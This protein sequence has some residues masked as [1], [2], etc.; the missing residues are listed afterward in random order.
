MA[1]D[2]DPG[3]SE[4][5][6]S[7]KMPPI[8]TTS[9]AV[10]DASRTGLFDDDSLN[11]LMEAQRAP[12]LIVIRG[13]VPGSV[14]PLAL[15]RNRL[16]RALE[17]ECRLTERSISRFHAEVV[18]EPDGLSLATDLDSSNGTFLN[19][20]RLSG[21]TPIAISEGDR[22]RV[23]AVTLLKFAWLD[24]RE[25]RF[26]REMLDRSSQDKLTGLA[27]REYLLNRAAEL[28]AQHAVKGM[29]TAVLMLDIDNLKEINDQ[30]G[31]ASGND[32]LQS[33]AASIRETL[34]RDALAAR[35][36]G[37]EF[38][39]IMAADNLS[40]ASKQAEDLRQRLA[41]QNYRSP[42]GTFRVPISAGLAFASVPP[43]W[44][45]LISAADVCM[46]QGKSMGGNRSI[47]CQIDAV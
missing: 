15:G 17:N 26:H 14:H 42:K 40:E 9:T 19:G 39:I 3:L 21:N 22:L 10:L 33:L 35:Y 36:G 13:V 20:H 43:A 18:I 1:E 47:S 45:V 8:T 41:R 28:F 5:E 16:G 31:Y 32:V 46:F 24:A 44:D 37:E 25:Q 6:G 23:G 11:P 12:C 2:F 30:H 7:D 34:P 4:A 38:V 29:G 27:N